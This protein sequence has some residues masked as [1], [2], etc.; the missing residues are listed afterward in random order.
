M[1]DLENTIKAMPTRP[2]EIDTQ[3]EEVDEALRELLP[4]GTKYDQALFLISR[5][6]ML[7]VER[8]KYHPTDYT[9]N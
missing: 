4:E 2:E 8:S 7:E 1:N 9:R 5:K 3:L 6:V